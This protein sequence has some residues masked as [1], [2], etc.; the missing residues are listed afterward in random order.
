MGAAPR[1][2]RRA[3]RGAARRRC[4][5]ADRLRAL[6]RLLD[7]VRASGDADVGPRL[8]AV[9]LLM[10]RAQ[11]DQSSLRRAVWAAMTRAGDALVRDGHAEV[12]DF[13]LAW[14]TVFPD[15]DFA[16]V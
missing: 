6:V 10:A 16:I 5:V 2:R 3:R 14:P 12:T 13:L 15:E 9:R 8:A 4:R 11:L 7:G 1:A